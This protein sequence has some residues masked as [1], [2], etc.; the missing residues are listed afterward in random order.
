MIIS[1]SRNLVAVSFDTATYRVLSYFVKEHHD[2]VLHRIDPL[3]FLSTKNFANVS[4]INLIIKDIDLRK[5]I[6]F[7]IDDN[8][9]E[10]FT[11]I[12]NDSY[13][14]H[15][16]IG[17]GCLI[18]PL[19]TVYPT[20]ILQKDIIVHSNSTI[21]EQCHIGTGSFISGG[22]T[23]AGS[24]II[25]DY[26]QINMGSIFYDKI[27]VISDTVIGAGSVIQKDITISGTYTSL[28]KNN[29]QQIK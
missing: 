10:R 29:L 24:A 21:A 19:V 26:C 9:L 12:H 13:A 4:F 2:Y 18:C 22:V 3:E 11:L 16:N 7:F 15:A 20:A 5:K 23:I 6:T 1:S 8:N 17:P 14:N 28:I 27:S 25:G